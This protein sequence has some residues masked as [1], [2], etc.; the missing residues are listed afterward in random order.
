MDAVQSF[1]NRKASIRNF[2]SH[3]HYLCSKLILQNLPI[4]T[5]RLFLTERLAVSPTLADANKGRGPRTDTEN[6]D[7]RCQVD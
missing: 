4:D 1:E 3:N 2:E 6:P 5:D 7:K